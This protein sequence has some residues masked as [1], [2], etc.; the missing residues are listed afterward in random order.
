M[1]SHDIIGDASDAMSSDKPPS[2]KNRRILIVDDDPGVRSSYQSILQPDDMDDFFA[3][4]M[5]VLGESALDAWEPQEP[6]QLTL[7]ES[8]EQGLDAVAAA[9]RQKRHYALAFVDMSMPG[10]DGAKTVKHIW[11]M[12]PHVKI[13]IVTAYSK[14]TP[15]QIVR[16]AG[17]DDIL[18]LRKPFNPLEISQFA[19]ALTN[20]WNLER[21]RDRLAEN[22]HLANRNLEELN[23]HL[24]EKVKEKTALLIQSE[25]MSSLGVLVAGVAH[26]INNPLSFVISNLYHLQDCARSVA[27]PGDRTREGNTGKRAVHAKRL[28]ADMHA[29]I[30]EA[31]EGADRIAG[32]VNELRTFSRSEEVEGVPADINMIL[33][34]AVNLLRHELKYNVKLIKRAGRLPRIICSPQKL[35]Q[36]F[37]NL[38]MNAVQAIEGQGTITISTRAAQQGRHLTSPCIV[39]TIADTGKGIP[40]TDHDKIFDPFFTTKPVGEGTGL[41]LSIAWDIV[42]HHSGHIGVKSAPGQGTTFTVEL[43]AVPAGPAN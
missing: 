20:Q 1:T 35:S 8:G 11:T 24:E 31:L 30:D 17:R 10:L 18:Y 6:Y 28:V 25:K 40:A 34:S 22:L 7:T 41:G 38:L 14:Y 43:P 15:D 39:T 19:R 29:L 13:V 5:E 36:L 3:M 32:I 2:P 33:D 9:V 16:V 42:R 26:E 21:E 27:R 12:D 23:K 37:L 4:G